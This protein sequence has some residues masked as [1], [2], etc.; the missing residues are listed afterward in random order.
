MIEKRFVLRVGGIFLILKSVLSILNY[1]FT[2]VANYAT[3]KEVNYWKAFF[4]VE[5]FKTIFSDKNFIIFI[6]LSILLIMIGMLVIF[7]AN[8]TRNDEEF[9]PQLQDFTLGAVFCIDGLVRIPTLYITIKQYQAY[10]A[11][12]SQVS[13]GINIIIKTQFYS[14]MLS[15]VFMLLPLIIG[16]LYILIGMK[17]AKNI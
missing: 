10:K 8:S 3:S 14:L 16:A 15:L 2:L 6:L 9:K 1:F 11:L 5:Y 17:K 13:V 7:F 4:S 12:G